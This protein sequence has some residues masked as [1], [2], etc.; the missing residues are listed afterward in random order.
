[1]MMYQVPSWCL[2]EKKMSDTLYAMNED[3]EVWIHKDPIECAN[4]YLGDMCNEEIYA[5]TIICIYEGETMP[6]MLNTDIQF[7]DLLYDYNE[8][9]NEDV[10]D[11]L[12]GKLYDLKL[13]QY[14][15]EQIDKFMNE[16]KVNLDWKTIVNIKPL[17]LKIVKLNEYDAEWDES[18]EDDYKSY[19]LKK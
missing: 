14:L 6:C 2:K 5:G 19:W 1:M 15:S 8:D 12:V 3:D 9:I 18:N 7:T 16:K 10:L 11:E 17:Y 13:N 4:D